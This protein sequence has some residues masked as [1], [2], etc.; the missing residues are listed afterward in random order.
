MGYEDIVKIQHKLDNIQ[1]IWDNVEKSK[2]KFKICVQYN[3]RIIFYEDL[4]NHLSK[5]EKEGIASPEE[6]RDNL[7]MFFKC[8]N[9]HYH[10][11][12]SYKEF[13]LKRFENGYLWDKI[14]SQRK[15]ENLYKEVEFI[16][17]NSTQKII[18]VRYT[19]LYNIIKQEYVGYFKTKR[20]FKKV[21]KTYF[22]KNNIISIFTDDKEEFNNFT[23]NYISILKDK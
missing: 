6:L 3:S 9:T 15:F 21:L 20:E 1:K 13:A 16:D 7:N 14:V 12:K 8:E 10:F 11:V 19:D 5:E 4:Y 22:D 18:S 23:N 2:E 17:N